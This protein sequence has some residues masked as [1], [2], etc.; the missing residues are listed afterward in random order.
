MD[1]TVEALWKLPDLELVAAYHALRRATA[2]KKFERDTE[3]ARLQWQR[4]RLF[5]AGTG[6]IAEREQAVDASEE[7][8]KKGQHVRELTRDLDLLKADAGAAYACLRLRGL[9]THAGSKADD[10]DQEGDEPEDARAGA[11]S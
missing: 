10:P 1:I 7:L 2:E 6:R 5:I 11:S 8:A 3:R 4:A 9:A